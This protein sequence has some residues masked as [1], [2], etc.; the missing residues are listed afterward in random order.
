MDPGDSGERTVIVGV[1][2]ESAAGERRVALVPPVGGRLRARGGRGVVEP[3]AGLGAPI[4]GAGYTAAGA[5][6]GAPWTADAVLKVAP[7]TPAEIARLRPGAV[8]VG[9][10]SPL[11]CPETVAALRAAGVHGFAME[12]V[13]RI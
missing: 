6:L 4:P 8:L 13:P 9:F 12:A 5:E 10:L 11:T 1:P 7:P 3:G 2:R